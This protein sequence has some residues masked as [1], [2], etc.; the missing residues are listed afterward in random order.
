M[1]N[2]ARMLG[3]FLPLLTLPFSVACKP[4]PVTCQAPAASD[5]TLSGVESG[6]A[7]FATDLLG[8]LAQ[9]Q[10]GSNFFY[11][12]Y[13]I[14]TALA[15]TYTGAATQ[16]AQQMAQVLHLTPGAQDTPLAYA[17]LDCQIQTNGQTDGNQVDIGNGLFGQQGFTFLPA[18]LNT[19]A[20]DYGAPLQQVDFINNAN[21]AV[22]TIDQ[23]VSTETEGQIPQ[24]FAP[25]SLDSSVRLVLAN[26]IYF[27]GNWLSGFKPE[28]TSPGS[29]STSSSSQVQT[30]LM[31]QTANFGYT[32]GQDF[33]LL[34]LPYAGGK[35]AMDVVLPG[36]VDGLPALVSSFSASNFTSWVSGLQ[37]HLVQVTLPKFNLTSNFDLSQT[38]QTMGMSLAFTAGSADFSGMD[39][40]HDLFIGKVIHQATVEVDESGSV[41]AAATAVVVDIDAVA[42]PGPNGIIFNANH[43]FLIVLRDLSTGTLLF[44]GQVTDP[45]QS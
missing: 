8:Q 20:N 27:K 14:S 28:N 10:N 25:G 32:A 12:P 16:T 45:S 26:A 39:G 31:N 37:S 11:S 13:S 3:T 2:T 1:K 17:Q 24:L 43:P 41:A 30:P 23:W 6:N 35:M 9:Q 29:F 15:M 7:E 42:G 21:G 40:Q 22:T 18:F 44:V 34:E 36:D 19:L 4:Q 33:A 38:L 5:G